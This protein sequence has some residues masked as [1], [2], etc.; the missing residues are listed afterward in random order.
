MRVWL[1]SIGVLFSSLTALAV[2]DTFK[3]RVLLGWAV[4]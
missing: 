1:F 3:P 4:G 2:E